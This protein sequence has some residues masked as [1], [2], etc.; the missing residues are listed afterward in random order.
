MAIKGTLLALR[1]VS[2][3]DVAVMMCDEPEVKDVKRNTLP[4]L[5]HALR[6]CAEVMSACISS[7]GVFV[8]LRRER[9]VFALRGPCDVVRATLWGTLFEL[10]PRVFIAM[11]FDLFVIANC[12]KI[13]YQVYNIW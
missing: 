13:N 10:H 7:L 11:S 4:S 6:S 9:G 2:T 5:S 12:S 8:F 1:I 3:R